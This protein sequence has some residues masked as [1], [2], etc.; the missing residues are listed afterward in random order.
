[1]LGREGDMKSNCNHLI[2]KDTAQLETVLMFP[3]I[4]IR[5]LLSFLP[6]RA[7]DVNQLMAKPS[8]RLLSL[9][10]PFVSSPYCSSLSLIIFSI[11]Y[12]V[13]SRLGEEPLFIFVG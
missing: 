8:Y 7:Q 4:R 12:S 11:C 2:Q 10:A 5:L 9:A 1:M 3:K 13:I 6:R